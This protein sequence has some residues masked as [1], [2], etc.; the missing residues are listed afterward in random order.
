VCLSYPQSTP[1]RTEASPF[2]KGRLRGIFDDIMINVERL[3]RGAAKL[4]LYLIPIQLEQFD[5]YY[6]ELMEWNRRVNLTAITDH[7]EV[8]IM[9]FLDALTVTLAWQQPIAN[10]D[11]DLIDVGA[12]AGIPGIPLKIVFPDIELVLL[13]STAKKTAFLDHIVEKLGLNNVEI[14]TGRAEE[15]ARQEQYREK[16]DVVLS[17]AVAA[18][19]TL[20]ELTLPFC[21]TGGSFIAQKKGDIDHEILSAGK[22]ISLLGGKLREVKRIEIEEFTDSRKLIIIDKVAATPTLYPRRSGMPAKR[23]LLDKPPRQ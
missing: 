10:A 15:I 20:L 14:V 8:Q 21:A 18:L 11:F 9:H 5:T 3:K 23:P 17:R 19:P 7:A 4:G 1:L 2:G 13:D 16:F 6:H 12:G 22:A